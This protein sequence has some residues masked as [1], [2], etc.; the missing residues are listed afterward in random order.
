M[1]II[2]E[3]VSHLNPGQMTIITGDQPVYA[4][5]KQVNWMFPERY[6]NVIW[7]M[8]P[9]HIEMAFLSAI[10]DWHDGCGWL[11]IFEKANITT[12]GR[13]ESLLTGKKVKRT[14][15]VHQLSLAALTK[16]SKSA[17]EDQNRFS[18]FD[19]WKEHSIKSNA[20]ACYWFQVI[21]L[22]SLLFSFIKSLRDADYW[23]FVKYL[24]DTN[25]W[26]FVL[27]HIHYA[28]WMSVFL[29]DLQQIHLKYPSVFE[30]FKKGYFTVKNS[31]R[32]FSNIGVDQAH[33]QNNKLVK[34]D[35]GAIDILDN[36]NALLR[37]AVAGPVISLICKDAESVSKT[38]TTHHEDTDCFE[39]KFRT[40]SDS[41]FS[42]FL[43]FGNPFKEEEEDL[44]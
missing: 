6:Q 40:D 27:D 13:I 30:A 1:N 16:L 22:E 4:I 42:A 12:T 31:S 10:G 23:L 18:T 43:E 41:L 20:N 11:Q 37:W 15:Y 14:R 38:S 21:E 28:R 8:G 7:M 26:M 36:P 44:V 5:G 24:K 39:R 17:F 32:I 25:P 33:E 3:L 34:I 2:E 29:A 35:G 9:L 19:D